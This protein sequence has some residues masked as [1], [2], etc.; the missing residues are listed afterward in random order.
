MSECSCIEHLEWGLRIRE[1]HDLFCARCT[2]H[3][4]LN[5]PDKAARIAELEAALMKQQE[6]CSAVARVLEKAPKGVL[7]MGGGST[8]DGTHFYVRDVLI[9]WLRGKEERG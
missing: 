8:E 4:I 9:Q 3:W 5:K 6:A 1:E 2:R 7:G